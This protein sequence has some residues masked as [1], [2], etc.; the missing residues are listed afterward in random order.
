VCEKSQG[1]PEFLRRNKIAVSQ[2]RMDSV[3]K[4]G[5]D[6][7]RNVLVDVELVAGHEGNRPG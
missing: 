6:P 2:F 5:D 1:L 7:T 3:L 4:R